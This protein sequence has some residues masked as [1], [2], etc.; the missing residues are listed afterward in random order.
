MK[1]LFAIWAVLCGLLFSG[2]AVS[3][4]TYVP[5][6]R[7]RP[8]GAHA[9]IGTIVIRTQAMVLVY[10][11]EGG[12]FM[13]AYRIGVG[14]DG[15]RWTGTTTVERKAKWPNWYPPA[16]MLARQSYLPRVMMG[17]PHNPL[18]ARALYLA[19][20]LYR[21]HGTND[22]TS[23]GVAESSGCIRMMNDDVMDLYE[24]VP[25]GTK[26]IVRP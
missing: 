8:A 26:V 10:Y 20:T 24:R 21:I 9:P 5:L 15:F 2:V 14:R 7:V 1:L 4:H 18:G 25:V 13:K 11:D 22:P 23:I 19:G 3:A 6:P 12:A 17:G 16:D